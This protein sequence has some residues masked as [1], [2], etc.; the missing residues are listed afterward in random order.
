MTLDYLVFDYSEGDDDTGLF[1]ALAREAR[2]PIQHRVDLGLHRSGAL[3]AALVDHGGKGAELGGIKG[4]GGRAAG[5]AE[6]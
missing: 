2:R 1:D 4:H 3:E 5:L 6:I